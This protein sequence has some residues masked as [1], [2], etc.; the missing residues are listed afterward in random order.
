MTLNE[1]LFEKD[2]ADLADDFATAEKE[3]EKDI[4]IR[5]TL[6]KIKMFVKKWKYFTKKYDI[7]QKRITEIEKTGKD[8]LKFLQKKVSNL[9][10]VKT[11]SRDETEPMKDYL[12]GFA[13]DLDIHIENQKEQYKKMSRR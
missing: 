12:D 1:L 9:E 8:L 3:L 5:I 7:T 11:V 4:K 6:D 13:I 2:M 10:K